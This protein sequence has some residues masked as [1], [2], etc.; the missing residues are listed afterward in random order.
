[1][2]YERISHMTD[3]ETY[4]QI[5]RKRAEYR[6][7][8]KELAQ[9]KSKVGDLANHAAT[10][11]RGLRNPELIRWWEGLPLAGQRQEHIVLTPA[12]FSELTVEKIKQ[13]CAELKRLEVVLAALRQELMGIDEDPER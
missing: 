8:K 1:M 5:G 11:S 3:S 4:E 7:R 12:M 10:I 2:Y 6:E 13:F 9:L